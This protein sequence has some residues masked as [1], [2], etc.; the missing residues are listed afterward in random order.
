MKALER[1]VAVQRLISLLRSSSSVG[2]VFDTRTIRTDTDA[3]VLELI[4]LVS[5][6]VWQNG[7][8]GMLKWLGPGTYCI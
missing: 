3:G 8:G 2:L 4:L 7:E 6:D 5:Q 1:E